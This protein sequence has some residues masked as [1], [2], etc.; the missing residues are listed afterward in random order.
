MLE[1]TNKDKK[2]KADKTK[3]KKG[4][5][6]EIRKKGGKGQGQ[7]QRSEAEGE[8]IEEPIKNQKGDKNQMN[9]L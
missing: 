4:C 6:R 7:G 5:Q 8:Q 2:E 9:L 3:D 1:K